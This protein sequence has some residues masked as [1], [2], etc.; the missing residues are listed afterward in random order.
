MIT[1]LS[2]ALALGAT[3]QPQRA[4][5][6]RRAAPV[7]RSPANLAPTPNGAAPPTPPPPRNAYDSTVTVIV[8]V[9]RA[10]ADVKAELDRFQ[11]TAQG[12]ATG[13]VLESSGN[14][15]AK[16]QE[17]TA[18]ATRGPRMMCRH[19]GSREALAAFNNY[20]L[21]LPTLAQ[22]GT[23]CSTTLQRLRA[24]DPDAA[25]Q[26]LKRE[27]RN[28]GEFMVQGLRQYEARLAPVR[29]ALGGQPPARRS[30]P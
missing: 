9:G 28:I 29:T 4:Q 26:A 8:N 27:Q 22:L 25:A 7:T 24:R 21:F 15:K 2:L 20:R 3:Q 17:L 16:C 1:I 5:P 19:C 12:N 23:R 18:V 13:E 30:G 10:V 6:G 14:F 11:M